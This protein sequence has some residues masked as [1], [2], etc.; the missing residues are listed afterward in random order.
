MDL[1]VAVAIA[2]PIS[3]AL[4]WLAYR[5]PSWYQRAYGPLIAVVVLAWVALFLWQLAV[6]FSE[7][8]AA[9]FVPSDR[10]TAFRGAIAAIQ[11]APAF[12]I[13]VPSGIMFY[14]Y[15]LNRWVTQMRN[16]PE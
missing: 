14:L 3:S 2:I 1:A 11:I 13:F 12:L 5:H 8:I 6:L 7:Y 10:L 15:G 4:G 16:G 9:P